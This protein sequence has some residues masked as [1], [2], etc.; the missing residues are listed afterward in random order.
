MP[1]KG[2]SGCR[3]M[4]RIAGFSS[5]NRREVPTKVPLVPKIATKCVARPAVCR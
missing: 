3:E 4:Q 1:R 2:E 5:F